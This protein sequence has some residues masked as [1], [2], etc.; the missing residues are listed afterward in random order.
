MQLA[1]DPISFKMMDHLKS[2]ALS[3][4]LNN[5]NLLNCF[6]ENNFS[7]DYE[8]MTCHLKVLVINDLSLITFL[9]YKFALTYPQL[10]F[11]YVHI[12]QMNELNV[13]V[14]IVSLNTRIL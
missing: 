12:N 5:R 9:Q 2:K 14:N 1:W 3:K 10:L 13:Q 6:Q 4:T 8:T 11:K 7:F